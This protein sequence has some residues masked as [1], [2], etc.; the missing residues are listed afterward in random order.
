MLEQFARFF[1]NLVLFEQDVHEHIEKAAIRLCISLLQEKKNLDKNFL[2]RNML[3]IHEDTDR[4]SVLK[5]FLLKWVEN[6]NENFGKEY[7]L[8]KAP[9][10]NNTKVINLRVFK[11]KQTYL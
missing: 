10:R 9:L 8:R 2:R 3:K 6:F 5:F 7:M 11:K 1:S 4:I